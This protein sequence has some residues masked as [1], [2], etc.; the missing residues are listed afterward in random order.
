MIFE[1]KQREKHIEKWKKDCIKNPSL[2]R[3]TATAIEI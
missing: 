2:N 3:N 1:A